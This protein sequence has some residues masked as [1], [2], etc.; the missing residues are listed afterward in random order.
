ML[1]SALIVWGAAKLGLLRSTSQIRASAYSTLAF[2][3]LASLFIVAQVAQNFFAAQYG[4]LL[5]GVIA[6]CFLFAAQPVQRLIERRGERRVG[7]EPASSQAELVFKAA[8]RTAIALGPLTREH[9]PH[10]AEVAHHL[11][12]GARDMVRLTREVEREAESVKIGE[13]ES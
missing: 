7:A 5:G 13:A 1:G 3:S 8:V 6:G 12:I 11:G 9:D 4:L 10:L 2:F